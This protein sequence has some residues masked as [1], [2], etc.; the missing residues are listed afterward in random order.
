MQSPQTTI[1][2]QTKNHG[3]ARKIFVQPLADIKDFFTEAVQ[4]HGKIFVAI[5]A[6]TYFLQGFRA[7]AFGGAIS[8]FLRN[9]GL[10]SGDVQVARSNIL[11]TWNIKFLYGLLFDNFPILKRHY[12]PYYI[13]AALIALASALVLGIRGVI[14]D[15]STSTAMLFLFLMA[16]AMCDVIA[17]A[18]VVKKARLAGA[19][20]G[21]ALQT[22]CW[23]VYYVG[24]IIGLPISG[25][26]VGKDGSNGRINNLYLWV[27]VPSAVLLLIL[28]F[29][30]DEEAGEGKWTPMVFVNNFVRLLRSIFLNRYVFLPIL[31]IF[32]RGSITPDIA[33][34][35]DFWLTDRPDGGLV[36][37]ADT[38][39]YMNQVGAAT[40]II[41]LLAYG[42]FFTGTPFRKIFFWSQLGMGI[43]GLM[44]VALYKQWNVPMGFPDLALYFFN[45]SLSNAVYQLTSMP[46]LVMAAQLAPAD[47]EATFFAGITS[48]SN[49]G[50][51]LATLWSG[52]MLIALGVDYVDPTTNERTY[53]LQK[54]EIAVWIRFAMTFLPALLVWLVPNSSSIDPYGEGVKHEPTVAEVDALE[55]A[56]ADAKNLEDAKPQEKAAETAE[57]K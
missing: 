11:I 33:D 46:F 27:Y 51:N 42:K 7:Y 14:T 22:F 45:S 44:D 43:I 17:D 52:K 26:I 55:V 8:W 34:A 39:S 32:L 25:N 35:Y 48:V 36:I 1:A 31:F 30:V 16:M 5:I 15:V 12:K 6:A 50:N 20:G 21:A 29:F 56:D 19:R 53:D 28:S 2:E 13:L 54:L 4:L 9:L 38:Q 41:G 3:W 57:A 37:G 47:I 18:L 24:Y 49:G 10:S 23:I 40:S